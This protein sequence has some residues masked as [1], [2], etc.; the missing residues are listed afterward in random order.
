MFSN[1]AAIR[2]DVA[3]LLATSTIKD[4]RVEATLE[5]TIK[6]TVP[7]LYVE[8]VAFDTSV[9][10]AL[11]TPGSVAARFNL[12]LT[13]PRTDSGKSEAEVDDMVPALLAVIDDH[14]SLYWTNAEKRRIPDG[15]L[16]WHLSMFA[17]TSLH[18]TT[19]TEP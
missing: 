14:D 16:A 1:L 13:S 11:L 3:T 15:P 6:S 10:G 17:I 4:L 8:F 18:P 9:E 5:G 2:N 7:V 19:T 12:L